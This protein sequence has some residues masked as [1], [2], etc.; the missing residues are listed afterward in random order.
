HPARVGPGCGHRLLADAW[1]AILRAEQRERFVPADFRDVVHEV[2][3]HLAQQF[4]R[5]LINRGE[6]EVA[7]DGPGPGS[8]AVMDGDALRAAQFP[9]RR[10]LVASPESGAKDGETQRG[11][12]R[13]REGKE[14]TTESSILSVQVNPMA[15]KVKAFQ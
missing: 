9:P 4:L 13:E 11:S 1:D 8:G 14:L 7:R 6:A 10:E 15:A 5:I 3:L 12:H 2:R